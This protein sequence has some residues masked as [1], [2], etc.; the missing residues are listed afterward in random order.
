MSARACTH[1][2]AHH[3]H[4]APT[5]ACKRAR[6]RTHARMHTCTHA[7]MHACTHVNSIGTAHAAARDMSALPWPS[8][9]TARRA[10]CM[11]ARALQCVLACMRSCV[12]AYMHAR[13]WPLPNCCVDTILIQ[14]ACKRRHVLLA[15]TLHIVACVFNTTC[16]MHNSVLPSLH[17]CC[18]HV[19]GSFSPHLL[20]PRH[21]IL[22]V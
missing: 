4:H 13:I 3:T 19:D 22:P 11:R 16:G 15:H 7:R 1:W 17:A 2:G 9:R 18:M 20:P 8:P 5:R 10:N 14:H 6:A 21:R 12:A